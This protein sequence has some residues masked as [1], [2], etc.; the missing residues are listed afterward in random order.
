MKIA[1]N[2]ANEF[3]IA[4][5]VRKVQKRFQHENKKLWYYNDFSSMLLIKN[6]TI[7]IA[8]F[9]VEKEIQ[10]QKRTFNKK[11]ELSIWE[12][13]QSFFKWNFN[14]QHHSSLAHLKGKFFPSE[15]IIQFSAETNSNEKLKKSFFPVY[16]FEISFM[17]LYLCFALFFVSSRQ[18]PFSQYRS[19]E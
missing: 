3:L 11:T 15:K 14:K 12:Q 6:K 7:T 9:A 10:T 13:S 2:N 19:Q 5:G 18:N 8:P 17:L 4:L 16:K 1:Q